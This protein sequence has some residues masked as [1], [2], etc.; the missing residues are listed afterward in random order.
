[1]MVAVSAWSALYAVELTV[2]DI[3]AKLLYT[4][5]QFIMITTVPA[6]WFC[7]ALEY[8]GR[9]KWL[10][11]RVLA[12]LFIHPTLTMITI[13][14]NGFHHLFWSAPAIDTTDGFIHLVLT[15]G[16]LFWV[17]ATY[18]Y[19]LLLAG[20]F[21][22]IQAMIR[23]P[24]LYRGQ[25][26]TLLVGA[27]TPWIANFLF[28]TRLSPFHYLDLTPFAF[29]IT[30]LA[31]YWSMVRFRFLD[32][33][34]VARDR[35]FES[36]SDAFMVLD[37][38]NRVVDINGAGLQIMG[39]ASPDGVI[40]RLAGDVLTGIQDL[41]IQYRDVQ[42]TQA[43]IV[44]PSA[45]KTRYF[46]LSI[47]PLKDRQGQLTGRMYLL[48]EITELK[49]ANEQIRMQNET[50]LHTN[51]DLAE[52]QRQAEE[53]SHLKSEF[54]ATMSHELR[55]PLNAI[56]GFTDLLLTGLPGTLNPKQTDYVQRVVSNGERLLALIN[57]LL[58][59]AKI[60][61]ARLELADDILSPAEL[62]LGIDQQLRS[63]ADQKGLAFE[64]TLDPTLP[65]Q[66]KG[67]P[68]RLQQILVNLIGNAIRFT[69]KGQIGV[70]MER[71]DPERWRLSVA[72]TGVGIPAHAL[73]Y[74]FEEF[75]QADGS[76]T[77]QYGG[78]GLG[79]AIVRKLAVLMGGTVGVKSEVGK[80]S[81]F[82]VDLPLLAV[83]TPLAEVGD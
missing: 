73:E 26:V 49:Q 16:P 43:E 77:R 78:T 62:L 5:L 12:L 17:H 20:T 27:F 52:A 1:M 71:V 33:V 46:Q 68:K 9:E 4:S 58:D 24:G 42:E 14:S 64:T 80:G 32:I 35:L 72:D 18:S 66:I 37:A 65:P 47:S 39:A 74:I 60:E 53:A 70:R 83:E 15:S 56:I 28:I 7:F 13:W 30:G 59:I 45:G 82:T 51:L 61:A 75:R 44:I 57:D 54:L 23:Q 50:L 2:I 34:P 67:D 48:H 55:T 76:S 19:L 21:L 29:T 11:G 63:L 69:E 41:V 40:G 81:E 8:T 79:L 38:Q 22:L 36:M 6:G 10:T 25:T 3:P 31:V